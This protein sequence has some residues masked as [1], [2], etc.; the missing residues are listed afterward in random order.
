MC[1]LVNA[2]IGSRDDMTTFYLSTGTPPKSSLLRDWDRSSSIKRPTGH[3]SHAPW[4]KFDVTIRVP[5]RRLD[6]WLIGQPHISM[7][8]FIWAD[9]QGAEA[10]LIKGAEE[11][12]TRTRYFYTEFYNKELYEGQPNLQEMLE[13][14]PGWDAVA[15]YDRSNILLQNR[16]LLSSKS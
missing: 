11:T 1:E 2:A 5:V 7:I 13:M 9:I 6:T 14:L 8:D 12:L 4:C 3:L 10:D 16:D 15:I